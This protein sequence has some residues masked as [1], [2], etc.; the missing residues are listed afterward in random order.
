MTGYI[1]HSD[2]CP[3]MLDYTIMAEND[4][5]Y[6]TPPCYTIYM[7]GLVFEKL[8]AE[9]GLKGMEVRTL[10]F[11]VILSRARKRWDNS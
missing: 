5:M 3:A 2:D 4:S 6:N 10:S 8:L 9:G 11:S 7:C 1:W